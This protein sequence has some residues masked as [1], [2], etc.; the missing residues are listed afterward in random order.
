MRR[1]QG[2]HSLC[3]K[4]KVDKSTTECIIQRPSSG[5]TQQANCVFTVQGQLR[6]LCVYR[7]KYVQ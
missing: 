3:K 6:F 4:K 7:F 2:K 5:K 1:E